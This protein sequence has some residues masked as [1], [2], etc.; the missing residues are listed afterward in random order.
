M[1][2]GWP[3]SGRSPRVLIV[4]DEA[5]ISDFVQAVLEDS[6][7]CEVVGAAETG[8]DALVLAETTRP[9]LALVDITLRGPMDGLELAARLRR[10]MPGL[11]IV[12]ATGS[13]DPV[14]RAKADAL[15]PYGFLKKPFLPD[16]L[17]CLISDP[18]AGEE[19]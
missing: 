9:D 17:L 6:G 13:H 16:H 4:E 7:G 5:L 14:T 2:D 1:N 12:F 3:I 8:A 15:A 10:L 11:R 18:N 19:Q